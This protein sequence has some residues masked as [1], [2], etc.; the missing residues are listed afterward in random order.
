MPKN[1]IMKILDR[2]PEEELEKALWALKHIECRYLN[3]WNLFG[4]GIKITNL[5]EE[6]ESILAR[7][8]HKFAGH[9]DDSTKQEIYYD[10]FRWH[11]FSYEK[12]PCLVGDEARRAF[13]ALHKNEL[14]MMVERSPYVTLLSHAEAVTAQ[15]FEQMEDVYLFDRSFTW[16]YVKTHEES[17]GLGPYFLQLNK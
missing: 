10:Q 5:F 9:I 12:Q 4:K 17:L 11:L 7:W 8:D 2:L 16:T 15:D 3:N 13:D 14:Y 6:S 1:E